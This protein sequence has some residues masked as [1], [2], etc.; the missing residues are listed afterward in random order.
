VTR[1]YNHVSHADLLRA[2]RAVLKFRREHRF[3][4]SG[5]SDLAASVAALESDDFAGAARHFRR[6]PFG[7]MGTFNDWWPPVVYEHEDEDY[8]WTVSEALDERWLRLM[9][10]A[11][12]GPP[13]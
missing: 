11:S 8:V 4:E 1:F 9:T 12:G 2:G 6:I 10:A 7:G 13:E 5:L 3:P